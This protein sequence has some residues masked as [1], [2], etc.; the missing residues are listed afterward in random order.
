MNRDRQFT[1]Q[2]TEIEYMLL[3]RIEQL[4]EKTKA[5]LSILK[6]EWMSKNNYDRFKYSDEYIEREW[7]SFKNRFGL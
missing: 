3:S 6:A 7:K 4:E 1:V 5:I 2:L